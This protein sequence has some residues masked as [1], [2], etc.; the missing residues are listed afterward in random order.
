MGILDLPAPLF[1]GLDQVMG[2]ILPPSGRLVLWALLAAAVSM[3]LYWALSPQRKLNDVKHRALKARQDL[4]AFD[5][6]FEDAWPMMRSML[7][8]SIKQLGMTTMPAILASVPALALIIWLG[9]IY[10]YD[11]PG[12][13]DAIEVQTTPT[14]EVQAAIQTPANGSPGNPPRLVVTDPDGGLVSD[15]SLTAAIPTIH[16]KQWWNMLVGNPLGY[17]PSEG[18][19]EAIAF[20]LPERD[21]LGFGPDWL[22]PWY[23][24]FFTVLVIGSLAIKM[25]GRID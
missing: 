9:T 6:E 15:I 21:Y 23:M 5:G 25:I 20:D 10:G 18:E 16:K 3:G 12:K 8:L 22:R 13:T 2:N 4:N 11:L 17:L 14:T 1:A 24:L 19:I 7:G